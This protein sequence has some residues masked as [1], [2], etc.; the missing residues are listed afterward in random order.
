MKRTYA[1]MTAQVTYRFGQDLDVGGNYTLSKTHGN[2]DG[3]N[4]NAGPTTA[5]VNAY[6]EYKSPAWN[7]P[8]GDVAV[9]Q[10]HR[11]RIW[12]TYTVPFPESAGVITL[13]LIEQAA[14]GAPYAALGTVNPI[15]YV[16]NPGYVTPPAAVEYFYQPRDAFRTEATYRTDLSLNYAYRI[17]GSGGQGLDLFFRG[18]VINLFNQFQLCGCGASVFNNGGLTDLTTIGQAVRT[19]VNTAAM[20]PFNP[21]TTTPVQGTNWDYNTASFGRPVSSLAYTMPRVF[22]FSV[23]VRF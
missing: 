7:S 19:P 18:E 4:A 5:Q 14:S 15:P 13:G 21:F 3:E 6:P 23:G 20:Q 11:V 1:G 12:G 17:P 9:D 8:E 2:F 16:T 22:R 10:R